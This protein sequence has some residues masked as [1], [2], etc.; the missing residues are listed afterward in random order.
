MGIVKDVPKA[1]LLPVEYEEDDEEGEGEGGAE[2][3]EE[4]EE[5][6]PK[7]PSEA[8]E[9]EEEEEEEAAAAAP[10][11]NLPTTGRAM[12]KER[13]RP[14]RFICT[15]GPGP[16]GLDVNEKDQKIIVVTAK[17]WW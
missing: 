2:G 5:E 13:R 3:S 6:T 12:G 1:D 17:V 8:S 15:F 14:A 11:S 4:E 10:V 16:L 9:D 7:E